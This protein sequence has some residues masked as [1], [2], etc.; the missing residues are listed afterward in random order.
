MTEGTLVVSSN[1]GRYAL[2]DPDKGAELTSGKAC[3]ILLGGHWIAGSV[4][5]AGNLYHIS[6]R[7]GPGQVYEGFYFVA[8][9]GGV[10]GLCIGMRVRVS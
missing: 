3:E 1:R 10:C 2:D 8:D 4:E 6:G 9:D 5:H 7:G